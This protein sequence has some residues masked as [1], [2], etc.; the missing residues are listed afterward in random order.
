VRHV[1]G[2]LAS[3]GLA[4]CS[5]TNTTSSIPRQAVPYPLE[6]SGANVANDSLARVK[7]TTRTEVPDPLSDQDSG[8]RVRLSATLYGEDL[9]AAVLADSCRVDTPATGDCFR[10]KRAD[11]DRT[12]STDKYFR[13]QLDMQSTFSVN[14]LNPRF[15]DIYIRN[16]DGIMHEPVRVEM[17][18]PVIVRR[19]TLPAP[20]RAPV[21]RGLYRRTINLYFPLRT[22]FGGETLPPDLPEIRLVISK[23][24]REQAELVWE[25]KPGGAA[26]RRQR[27][28]G[29]DT[30]DF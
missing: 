10:R 11:Y 29:S 28:A 17:E 7:W 8:P 24:Q 15:W 1:A 12:H 23:N 22:P 26:S 21:R 4:A 5:P 18:A 30:V 25:I 20:G 9:I 13:I 27:R 14:S 6:L 19:D 3:I 16:E 2:L